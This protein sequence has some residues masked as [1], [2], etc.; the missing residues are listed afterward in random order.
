MEPVWI[1]CD[2]LIKQPYRTLIS[3]STNG[4]PGVPKDIP[5][6]GIF[7]VTMGSPLVSSEVNAFI[8]SQSTYCLSSEAFRCCMSM[9]VL[10]WILKKLFIH[11]IY[12]SVSIPFS[13]RRA[14]ASILL[15]FT[16]LHTDVP[17]AFRWVSS[18]AFHSLIKVLRPCYVFVNVICA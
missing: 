8:A 14:H 11:E 18:I 5:H 7:F 10:K 6:R 13:Y 16:L 4:A 3:C 1:F 9:G 2:F 12:L 15:L 17:E